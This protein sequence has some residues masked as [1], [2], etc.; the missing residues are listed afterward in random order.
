MHRI[1]RV[2]PAV[3]RKRRVHAVVSRLFAR[4]VIGGFFYVIDR[5]Q[6]GKRRA[7]GFGLE[8]SACVILPIGA[9]PGMASVLPRGGHGPDKWRILRQIYQP[10]L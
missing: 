10:N 9:P 2:A 1:H 8:A 6:A 3:R 5:R 4:A 7:T